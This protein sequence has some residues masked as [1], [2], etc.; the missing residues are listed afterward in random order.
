MILLGHVATDVSHVTIAG[1]TF[2]GFT[3]PEKA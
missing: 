3:L 2:I 1:Y